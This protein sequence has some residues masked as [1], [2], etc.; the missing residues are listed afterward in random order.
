VK[1]ARGFTLIEL[2]TALILVAVL[3]V[4]LASRFS[5]I[6]AALSTSRDD[7]VAALFYAQQVAMARD[8]SSNPVTFVVVDNNTISV[9]ENGVDLAVGPVSYPLDLPSGVTISPTSLTLD[10][11]KLGR[12]S[13]TTLTLSHGGASTMVTVSDS[14]YAQ[15]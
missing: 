4:A 10:Y 14:G 11:D 8:S 1:G 3:S 6:D 9:R 15:Q 13:G 5:G 7:T 2:I 12:T